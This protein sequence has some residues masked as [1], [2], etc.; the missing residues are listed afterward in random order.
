MPEKT[1]VHWMMPMRKGGYRRMQG[2]GQKRFSLRMTQ[3][4]GDSGERG[5]R[6]RGR[7]RE[8]LGNRSNLRASEIWLRHREE[9]QWCGCPVLSDS[10]TNAEAWQIGHRAA[11]INHSTWRWLPSLPLEAVASPSLW[12]HRAKLQ[13]AS[14]SGLLGAAKKEKNTAHSRPLQ[15]EIRAHTD[16]ISLVFIFS[17]LLK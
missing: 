17:R 7:R 5:K 11:G 10:V 4:E 16:N 9:E 12:F 14:I 1:V 13:P 15:A 6:H 2:N 3:R 8:E